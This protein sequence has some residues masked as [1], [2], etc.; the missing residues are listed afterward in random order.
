M[1][2]PSGSPEAGTLSTIVGEAAYRWRRNRT[3]HSSFDS[4]CKSRKNGPSMKDSSAWDVPRRSAAHSVHHQVSTTTTKSFQFLAGNC[5]CPTLPNISP[6]MAPRS[7]CFRDSVLTATFTSP[8]LQRLQTGYAVSMGR[9]L[10]SSH[11]PA[12]PDSDPRRWRTQNIAHNG[13]VRKRLQGVQRRTGCLTCARH[14]LAR[15]RIS[16][17]RLLFRPLLILPLACL[18]ALLPH[19]ALAHARV[20]NLDPGPGDGLSHA[21]GS[22]AITFDEPVTPV[23]L[24]ITVTSPTG[25]RISRG[26]ARELDSTL[27]VEVEGAGEG[28]YTVAWR[29]VARGTHPP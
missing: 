20:L 28:T 5:S 18:V 14:V 1:R 19:P 6:S 11:F 10:V 17:A 21:P 7:D 8:G 2:R 24:G 13:C 26:R 27:N 3:D 23:G 9:V 29:E 16:E 25:R 4:A 12:T 15:V 22:V